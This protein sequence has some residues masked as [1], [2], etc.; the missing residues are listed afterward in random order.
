MRLECLADV[1]QIVGFVSERSVVNAWMVSFDVLPDDVFDL[2][3]FE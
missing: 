2:Q 3:L 1:V